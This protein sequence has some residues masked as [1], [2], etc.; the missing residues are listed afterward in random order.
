[1]S[2]VQ[3]GWNI[4]IQGIDAAKILTAKFKNVRRVLKD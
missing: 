1:M 4:P 3:H 2:V